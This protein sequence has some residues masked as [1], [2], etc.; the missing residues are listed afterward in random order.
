MF[1][2]YLAVLTIIDARSAKEFQQPEIRQKK[3]TPG[4]LPKRSTG[5][6]A[7]LPRTAHPAK[8]RR[9]LRKVKKS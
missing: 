2:R 7:A 8:V 9:K 5:G 1:C 3:Q 6:V 4:P